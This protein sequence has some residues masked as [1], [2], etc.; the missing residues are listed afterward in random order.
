MVKKATGFSI[1]LSLLSSCFASGVEVTARLSRQAV[2]KG[3]PFELI[4]SVSSKKDIEVKNP[5]LPK[6]LPPFV[7]MNSSTSSS[8]SQSYSSGGGFSKNIK[9]NF[10]YTLLSNEEGEF[11][12]DPVSVEAD[13]K[14]HRTP[15]LK[16]KVSGEYQAPVPQ[17]NPQDLF[18][19]FQNRNFFSFPRNKAPLEQITKNDVFIKPSPL[20]LSVYVGQMF[21]VKWFI[22]KRPEKTFSVNLSP[23]EVIQP[24]NFWAEKAEEPEDISFKFSE[25]INSQIYSKA[26]LISYVFFP[27]KL[28]EFKIKPLETMARIFYPGSFFSNSSQEVFLKSPSVSIQVKPLPKEGRG[29]FTGAIG[30]FFLSAKTDRKKILKNDILSYKLKFEGK[31]A[32]QT[33]KLPPWPEDSDFKVYDILESQNFSLEKSW[34]EYEILLSAKK[35]GL[36][37][38]PKLSLT[39]FDPDLKSYISQDLPSIKIEVQNGSPSK[40]SGQKFFDLKSTEQNKNDFSFS[41]NLSYPSMY[42]KHFWKI[43]SGIYIILILSLLFFN[44]KFFRSQKRQSLNTLLKKTLTEARKMN[45]KGRYREV[46]SLLLNTMDQVWEEITGDSSKEIDK[47]I[48]KCPPSLRK[49]VEIELRKLKNQL[50][51]LSFSEKT[52]WD[53]DEIEKIIQNFNLFAKKLISSTKK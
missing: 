46:G 29:N 31:G 32:V 25:T 19:L 49:N 47:L 36:L 50:E 20:S 34:K 17:N 21:P 40:V 13:G 41:K 14:T 27:L 48:E 9:K 12:I 16:V 8:I 6:S 24:E 30:S 1:L 52:E 3:E 5:M 11:S 10:I 26:L 22:Y 44:R 23:F 7:L 4:I 35:T 38:T 37:K 43:W 28:G 39:T 2:S 53:F 45:Q 51:D 18:D 15:Q 42:K 33:I